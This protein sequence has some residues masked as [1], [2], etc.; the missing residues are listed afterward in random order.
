MKLN[1]SMKTLA[2]T[3]LT[4]LIALTLGCGYSSKA[5]TPATAGPIPA[6]EELAPTDVASGG[7]AFV[8]TVN[9]SNFSSTAIVN[10][11]GTP[12]PTMRVSA[13]QL[14]AT[15][16]GSEIA[17]PATVAITVTNPG[18]TGTG[19]YGSG[20]TVAETSTPMNFTVN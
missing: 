17:T 16:P 18:M 13:N 6:I 2:A 8:I 12:Q 19:A 9:G 14:T 11:N 1:L 20:G 10:W 7:P 4:A 3:L 15:I 5:T